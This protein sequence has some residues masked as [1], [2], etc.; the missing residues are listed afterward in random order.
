MLLPLILIAMIKNM[1]KLDRSLRLIIAAVAVLLLTFTAWIASPW[2]IVLG[3]VAGIFALT[4]MVGFCPLYGLFGISA[5]K[6]K[7]RA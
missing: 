3:I 6:V 7:G 1:S 4:S 2:N 5:C